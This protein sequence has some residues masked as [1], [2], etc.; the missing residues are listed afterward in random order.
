LKP[1]R[2]V[3]LPVGSFILL[4]LHGSKVNFLIFIV[5]SLKFLHRERKKKIAEV[6]EMVNLSDKINAKM[7]ELS[8]GCSRD[9]E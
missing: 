7:S 8:K 3:R 2:K 6:L 9:S 5:H 1:K 4:S